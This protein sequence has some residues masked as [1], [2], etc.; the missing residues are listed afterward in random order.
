MARGGSGGGRWRRLNVRP[1]LAS[2]QEG[3]RTLNLTVLRRLDPAVADILIIAAHVVLYSFDD[4]IHQWSRRPVEGSL[5]VVKRNTQPRFQFIVMNRK[6]TENLTEDLLGGFEYQVQ[7]PYIMY[8]NAADEITGIWFYD[9]QEC[10]QVGYLFS[11]IQKAFSRVSPKAKVSVTESEYEKPEVVPAVPSNEDTL[12]QPTSS[13]MLLDNAKYDFLS[14]LLKG[15][16]CVGATMDEASAVQSNKSVGMVHSSTHASP[17]AIPPQSPAIQSNKSFGMV[18]SS[19]QAPLAIP[20]QSPAIRSNKS[21]G[22]IHSSTHAS[23]FDIPPQSPAVQSNKSVGMIHSLTHASHLAIPP[24]SPALHGLHPSQI[25]AVPVMPHDAHRSSSTSTI[26]PT[27][28]ANPLFFPPMP[29]LQTASHAASSLCSAAPLHP[30]ITVQQLQ[31]APLHQPFSLPTASSIQPPYGM[32]LLQ[33]FPPPNPS[34][35][36]TSGVSY[37]RP[38]ITRDQLKDVL[39]SL[40]QNDEFI[41]MIYRE[42][43]KR[44]LP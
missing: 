14:A 10:E 22:M 26:Q 17:H 42:F 39:L 28:L 5:F 15:A 2:D 38:V 29:S 31:S 16:A 33:P 32:P 35:F 1:D 12:K 7:V 4:N 43:V 23:P 19:T 18:H 36:L 24:Q 8:H 41:D 9:P 40:C 11:R 25:S 20:P 3:T 30:P 44:Q 6:N 37:G 27:S 21:V 34:P 13:I